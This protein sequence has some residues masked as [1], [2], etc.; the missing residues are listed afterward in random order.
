MN[1]RSNKENIG[2]VAF[3]EKKNVIFIKNCTLLPLK[4]EMKR[5]RDLGKLSPKYD[6]TIKSLHFFAD[7]A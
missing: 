7:I 2:K 3:G 5:G 6:V 4:K 1:V